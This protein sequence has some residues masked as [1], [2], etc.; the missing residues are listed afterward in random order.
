[1]LWY[2]AIYLISFQ[3]TGISAKNL[4]QQLG[5]GSYQTAWTWLHK[6]RSAMRRMNR[7][8]LFGN[9]EVDETYVGGSFTGKRGRGSE[10]KVIIG[11]CLERKGQKLGRVRMEILPD[12]T[13]ASIKDFIN[14]NIQKNS[15]ILSDGLPSYQG[16]GDEGYMHRPVK[17]TIKNKDT[18]LSGIHLVVSLFKRFMLGTHQ[19]R[20]SEKHLHLFLDEFVFRFNRRKSAN[21][22]K[23]F[24]RLIDEGIVHQALPYW[25]IIGRINQNTPLGNTA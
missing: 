1:M 9:V 20:F 3:K 8:K 24:Y 7:D 14:V 6:I 23:V 11:V 12:V 13:A 10:N 5:F 4:Q 2:R 17:S 15:M 25:R 19:G 18:L 16:I 21:R 22:G